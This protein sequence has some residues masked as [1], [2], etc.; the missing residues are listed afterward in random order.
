MTLYFT[1]MILTLRSGHMLD[2]IDAEKQD[3][4]DSGIAGSGQK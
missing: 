3:G 1:W 2:A 4:R